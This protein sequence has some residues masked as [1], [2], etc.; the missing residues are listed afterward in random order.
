MINVLDN[1]YLR[2]SLKYR[3]TQPEWPFAHAVI[4]E[5]DLLDECGS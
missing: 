2:R 4:D 5:S 1:P 3:M